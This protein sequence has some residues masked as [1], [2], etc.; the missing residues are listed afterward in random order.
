MEGT[1]R[2]Q[3]GKLRSAVAWLGPD[4]LAHEVDTGVLEA[5]LSVRLVQKATVRGEQGIRRPAKRRISST[6]VNSELRLLRACYRWACRNKLLIDPEDPNRAARVPPW[7]LGPEDW[8]RARTHRYLRLSDEEVESLVEGLEWGRDTDRV[9]FIEMLTAGRYEDII[10]L[11][12][13]NYR[14]GAFLVGDT[15]KTGSLVVWPF[16]EAL[17]ARCVAWGRSSTRSPRSTTCGIGSGS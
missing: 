3:P 5:A 11:E 2:T 16:P 6:T 9:I 13:A 14:A 7:E 15:S 10:G 1:I 8:P 4:R 12:W 17:A